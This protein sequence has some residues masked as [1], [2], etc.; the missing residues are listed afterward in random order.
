MVYAHGPNPMGIWHS[1]KDHQEGVSKLASEFG[2]DIGLKELAE[3]G[4]RGHDE[5][6]EYEGWQEHLKKSVEGIAKRGSGPKHSIIGALCWEPICAPIA[7]SIAGHHGGLL[8]ASDFKDRIADELKNPIS[9]SRKEKAE[10][11]LQK[12]LREIDLPE[13]FTKYGTCALA[14]RMLHS[15]IVDADWLDTEAHYQPQKAAL[16]KSPPKEI[17]ELSLNLK[18]YLEKKFSA[19]EKTPVNRLRDK[20]LALARKRAFLCPGFFN[21]TIPSGGGKT[22]IGMSFSLDHAAFYGKKRVIVVL[23]YTSIIEQNSDLYRE[24][25]GQDSV[26][27]LHGDKTF[28]EK[29][30]PTEEK[31]LLASENC[32]APV[33]VTTNVEFFE[34]LF[35]SKNRRLRKLHNI[36]NSVILLDEVQTLPPELLKPTLDKLQDLVDYFGCTIVFSTATQPAYGSNVLGNH[37]IKNIREIIPNSQKFFRKMVRVK[38]TFSTVPWSWEDLSQ[39]IKEHSQILVIVNTIQDAKDL[40]RLLPSNPDL[41]YLSSELS[42]AHKRKILKTVKERLKHNLPCTLISTQTVEAGV[43][44]DFPTVFRAMGPLDSIV[45][46]GGRCNRE[47]KLEIGEVF[48]FETEKG[49]VPPGTYKDARDQTRALLRRNPDLSNLEIFEEYFSRFFNSSNL[50]KKR[51]LESEKGLNFKTTS[52]N[53]KL[54]PEKKISILIRR[55]E[56]RPEIERILSPQSNGRL[57]RWQLRALQPFMVSL[58]EKNYK[59]LSYKGLILRVE[60]FEDLFEWGG[61]YSPLFGILF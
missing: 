22:F 47:G 53:Y 11:N 15:C 2:A 12:I 23:P 43:D 30:N 39:K 42:G 18:E 41:F 29:L 33:I 38:Y 26:V 28:S 60:G 37:S 19:V 16:R 44:L 50:D 13:A 54:I 27:E 5:G 45:Q 32:D 6:K 52:K 7:F 40:T 20:M 17:G 61:E 51:I 49:N 48:V 10:K 1:L 56:D 31:Q 4:G 35:S 24:A 55:E 9:L 8:N 46:A 59:E 36:A 25:L 3:A 58:W 57:M 14:I 34:S 21:L